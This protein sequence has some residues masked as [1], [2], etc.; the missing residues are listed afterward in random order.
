MRAGGQVAQQNVGQDG[1]PSRDVLVAG[2]R[3]IADGR[4]PAVITIDVGKNETSSQAQLELDVTPVSVSPNERYL[5][6][7][8]IEDTSVGQNT[9][10]LGSVAFFP[11]PRLGEVRKFL[12]DLPSIT[13]Q[14]RAEGKTRI[15]LL[16][17]LVP[18]NSGR[19][20]ARSSVRVTGARIVG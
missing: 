12:F 15:D 8:S 7:V 16:V 4:S 2:T 18:V 11:P 3:A 1:R 9:T 5:L 13:A 10:R 17:A 19:S 20:L 14:M 6:V